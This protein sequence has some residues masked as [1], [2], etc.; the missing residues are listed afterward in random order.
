MKARLALMMKPLKVVNIKPMRGLT[1]QAP[2]VMLRKPRNLMVKQKDQPPKTAKVPGNPMVRCQ[3]LQSSPV[4]RLDKHF[5]AWCDHMLSE[6]HTGWKEHNEMQ[7]EH[8]ELSKEPQNRDPA[9]P[10]LDYMKQC[11]VFKAKK[12]NE[13]D[14]CR[15]Y[16]MELSGNLPPFP[17]PHEP[18][19]RVMLED[20]LRA[21]RALGCPNLLMAFTRDLATAVCLLQELHNKSSLKH[22]PLEP[23][24][25]ADGKMV[26][27]LSFCPFC[28]YNGSNDISYMNHIVGR[29]NS[30]AYGCRKCLKEVFLSG[31]QLKVHL[32]VCVGLPKGDT[33]SS[34]DKEP[35]PQG[36]PE[37]SQ[38][39]QGCSQHMKKKSDS[40]K[41]SS[42]HSK[43]HKSH[44]SKHPKEGTPK[45]E[46]QDKADRHKSGKSCKK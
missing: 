32:R 7:C 8:G 35:A 1:A 34:S 23:K 4:R 30:A 46:K 27:K 26:K 39:S 24:S 43:A 3:S 45:K 41:E 9:G 16:H 36:A 20:L 33:T 14:L 21:A 38:D 42:S 19:T 40:A 17:S 10:P 12:T 18:A 2:A 11:G 15:F 22:L 31:Q 13:Y 5:G 44:K 37:S 6:G 29:H 25:D 28:L